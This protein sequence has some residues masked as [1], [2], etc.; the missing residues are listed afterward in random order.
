M[1]SLLEQH[2]DE[3]WWYHPGDTFE[4]ETEV[5]QRFQEEFGT[6]DP[7][8]PHMAFEHNEPLCQDQSTCTFDF[9]TFEFGGMVFWPKAL[10]GTFKR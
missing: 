7:E 9:K 10:K 5:E 4:T 8:R 3:S 1:F 2:I 6:Y